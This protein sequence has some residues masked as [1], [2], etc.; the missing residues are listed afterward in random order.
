[1]CIGAI[2]ATPD[3]R[4]RS[5]GPCRM[6]SPPARSPGRP[7]SALSSMTS[8]ITATRARSICL[9]RSPP[10][11]RNAS[12]LRRPGGTAPI[13]R[14]RR[15]SPA[16]ISAFR[17]GRRWRLPLPVAAA[18]SGPDPATGGLFAASRERLPLPAGF[19]TTVAASGTD[20]TLRL[21]AAALAGI[22]QPDRLV[23]PDRAQPD[24]RR[25][26]P[27]NTGCPPTGS[28]CC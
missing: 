6:A 12:G 1:M 18:P 17:A 10:P 15:G 13:R 27:A 21:P 20:L 9:F 22:S 7:P 4:P 8:A 5:P 2:P 14:R 28:T 23:L 11:I 26:R 16:P 25:R 3:C 19:A 24:R